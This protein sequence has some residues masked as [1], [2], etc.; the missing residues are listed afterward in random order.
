MP[1]TKGAIERGDRLVRF[2]PPGVRRAAPTV[3]SSMKQFTEAKR[4]GWEFEG[5]H[6]TIVPEWG[7]YR[8]PDSQPS[9]TT[10]QTWLAASCWTCGVAS[11]A[12]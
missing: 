12:R 1:M 11:P 10:H 8:P 7:T 9:V 3:R 5:F 4:K 6:F 2:G